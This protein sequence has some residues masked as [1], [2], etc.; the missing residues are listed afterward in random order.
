MIRHV[1]KDGTPIEDITG[2]KVT[3]ETAIIALK[4]IRKDIRN[5][6]SQDKQGCKG[7]GE[8]LL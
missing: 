4:K 8:I 7:G 2:H 3:D 5:G 1:L 6:H